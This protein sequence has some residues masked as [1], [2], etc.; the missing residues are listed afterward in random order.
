MVK[1][2]KILSLLSVASLGLV[3]AKPMKRDTSE[4]T[5]ACQELSDFLNEKDAE[6]YSCGGTDEEDD[7]IYLAMKSKTLDQDMIDKLATYDALIEVKVDNVR[8]IQKDLDLSSLYISELTL[9]NKFMDSSKNTSIPRGVLKTAVNIYKL[10]F[11]RYNIAQ[12]NINEFSALS[13]LITLGFDSCT[14]DNDMDYHKLKYLKNLNE[15]YLGT[16]YI[17]GGKEYMNELPEDICQLKK[18]KT[19]SLYRNDLTT[20]P[21]CISNLKY[22]E[23]LNMEMNDLTVLPPEIGNLTRLKILNLNENQLTTLPAEIGNLAK[24]KELYL[25]GNKISSL[26]DEIGQ[27]TNLKKLNL[28]YNK[29]GSISDGLAQLSGLEILNLNSNKIYR[30]PSRMLSMT[31]LKELYLGSNKI[32]EIPANIH[33]LWRLETLVL[34]SNQLTQLPE[35]LSRIT[36]LTYLNVAENNIDPETIPEALKNLPNLEIVFGFDD[37][38]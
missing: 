37:D 28:S 25:E 14:F 4:F 32:K 15:L 31:H 5:G 22:L 17:N 16:T 9:D 34:S 12:K 29:I 30:I 24:L 21:S 2:N 11:S 6:L 33:K 35:S 10:N 36:N 27:L 26:P 8:T 18:L 23:K 19:L 1:F 38:E 20:L 7:I 13:Q 3:A